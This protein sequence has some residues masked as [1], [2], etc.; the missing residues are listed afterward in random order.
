M[1][2]FIRKNAPIR[3]SPNRQHSY[4]PRRQRVR[5]YTRTINRRPAFLSPQISRHI[6][7]KPVISKRLTTIRPFISSQSNPRKRLMAIRQTTSRPFNSVIFDSQYEFSSTGWGETP[8]VSID[9]GDQLEWPKE[10]G[11]VLVISIRPERMAKFSQRMG[12]WMK[13]MRR[14]PATDGRLIDRRKWVSTKKVVKSNMTPGRMGCYDSHV[15][16]WETI[17]QSPH[18]VVTVLEDDVD[19]EYSNAKILLSRMAQCFTELKTIQWDWLAWGHGPWAFDKNH[20][21]P[22]LKH[23]RKPGTCQGFFAYTLTRSMAL[24]L[25]TKC[26]PYKGPAVDKWFYDM[27]IR[28]VPVNVFTAQPRLCWVISAESDTSKRHLV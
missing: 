21:I 6:S 12:P 28:Q 18:S 19:W 7:R 9:T 5:I 4:S 11:P 16:I 17:A 24:K 8:T 2:Y 20:P 26:Y 22:N 3:K 15:R 13:H 14:F 10:M 25:L 1:P 27:F 23:W